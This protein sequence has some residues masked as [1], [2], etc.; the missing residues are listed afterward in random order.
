[1]PNGNRKTGER[2]RIQQTQ[3]DQLE[4]EVK[5]LKAE[6]VRLTG[7]RDEAQVVLRVER[8]RVEELRASTERGK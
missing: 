5:G 8:V 1:M 6:I 3:I 7:E 2:V 4:A